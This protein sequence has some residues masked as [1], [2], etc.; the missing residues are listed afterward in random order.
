MTD[1]E[2]IEQMLAELRAE[3]RE[4]SARVGRLE[5]AKA[6]ADTA[7]SSQE[8]TQAAAPPEEPTEAISEETLLVISAA[9]AAFLGERAHIRQ[10]RLVSSRAWAQEG[11]VSIQAS[12]L[13]R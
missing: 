5:T 13:L 12:H 6:A 1:S 2:R 10:V 8:S 4:L 7:D 3:M 11:R 9:V